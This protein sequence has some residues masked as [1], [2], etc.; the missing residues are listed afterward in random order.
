MVD[1]LENGKV[2]AQYA[3]KVRFI[4]AVNNVRADLLNMQAVFHVSDVSLSAAHFVVS[5]P[6]Y[7]AVTEDGTPEW[8]EG[9]E[10]LDIRLVLS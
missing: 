1:V 8:I 5:Y 3:E 7:C 6:S 4:R 2:V 9:A 10:R